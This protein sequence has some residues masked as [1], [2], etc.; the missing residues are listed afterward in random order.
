MPLALNPIR[1]VSTGRAVRPSGLKD[2]LYGRGTRGGWYFLV[3]SRKGSL[4][5]LFS[6]E[7]KQIRTLRVPSYLGTQYFWGL[8]SGTKFEG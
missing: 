8:K 3:K 4:N 6:V 7:S 5:S 1:E 2:T